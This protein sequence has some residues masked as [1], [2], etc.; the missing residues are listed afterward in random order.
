MKNIACKNNRKKSRIIS[1]LTLTVA[2]FTV[3][4]SCCACGTHAYHEGLDS[5]YK[6]MS[7]VGLTKYLIPDGFLDEF[8]YT[9]GEF[10]YKLDE[11][12][13]FSH[14]IESTLMCITYSD[15]IYNNVKNYVL[16]DF[17]VNEETDT[18][19]GSCESYAFYINKKSNYKTSS[20]HFNA[21]SYNDDT[22]TLIFIGFDS[23]DKLYEFENNQITDFDDLF[24]TYF[25]WYDFEN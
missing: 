14:T 8:E 25:P 15:S 12:F 22:Y 6:E 16:T 19:I 7:S 5:Y 11:P 4:V 18:A 24:K 9:D 3:A 17:E 23:A 13:P 2:V 10:Y 1:F 21:F 20:Q